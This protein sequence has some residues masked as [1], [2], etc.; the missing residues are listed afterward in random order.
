MPWRA[1]LQR[2]N[3]AA[4]WAT[5]MPSGTRRDFFPRQKDRRTPFRES[6][7]ASDSTESPS[8][9]FPPRGCFLADLRTQSSAN[10]EQC[11]TIYERKNFTRHS[12]RESRRT[13]RTGRHRAGCNLRVVRSYSRALG[14]SRVDQL[15]RPCV[16]HRRRQNTFYRCADSPRSL[17]SSYGFGH[18]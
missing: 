7:R 4:D 6:S 1:R 9:R 14:A 8:P 18:R 11:P 15:A 17:E 5:E 2:T 3:P 13:A 10:K 12:N 16:L